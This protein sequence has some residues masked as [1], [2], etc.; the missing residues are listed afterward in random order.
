MG[1]VDGRVAFITGAGRSQG[2]S[3]AVRLAEEGADVIVV[4]ICRDIDGLAYSLASSDDLAETAEL[5]R[6][7]G[8]RAVAAEIDVRD[9]DALRAAVDHGV[10]ELGRLDVVVANAGIVTFQRWDAVTDQIWRDSLDT[11]ATGTWNAMSVAIPHLISSGGGSMIGISSIAGLKGL[12]Y[13]TP[14]VAAK[15]AIVGIARS[16]AT[17]L[18]PQRIRVNTVHPTGVATIQ[19]KVGRAY[20]EKQAETEPGLP[21]LYFNSLPVEELAPSDVSDAVVFLASDESKYITGTELKVDAG[22]TTR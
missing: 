11:M 6:K 17:E 9:R 14:Y 10:A 1:R 15:H 20:L 12:P 7:T 4:D 13:Q 16:L 18:G 21:W 2:R 22:N 5:V 19:A 3:H 8:R